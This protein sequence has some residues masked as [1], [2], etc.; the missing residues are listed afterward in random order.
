MLRTLAIIG[1]TGGMLALASCAP[2]EEPRQGYA[3]ADD[4]QEIRLVG[5]PVRCLTASRIG[6][7]TVRGDGVIDFRVGSDTYRNILRSSCPALRRNDAITYEVRGSQ[8][9]SGEI[10]YALEDFGGGLERGPACSLGEFQQIEFVDGISDAPMI[11][12]D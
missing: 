7:L 2:V 8:L 12:G 3:L 11:M 6:S 5:E 1:A 10:V 9:C 4:E